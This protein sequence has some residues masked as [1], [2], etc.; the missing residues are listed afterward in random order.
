VF[1]G[2]SGTV[3]GQAVGGIGNV[4]GDGENDMFLSM[5][6]GNSFV[7]FGDAPPRP[8]PDCRTDPR[9]ADDTSSC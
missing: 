9:G 2:Q 7:I 6:W 1:Y 3:A 5:Y 4:N 8:A